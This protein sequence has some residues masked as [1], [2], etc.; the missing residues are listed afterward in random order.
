MS[1]I[2]FSSTSLIY[3][4]QRKTCKRFENVSRNGVAFRQSH[5]AC[6]VT[7]PDNANSSPII[8]F[9]WPLV[10]SV[11]IGFS[12]RIRANKQLIVVM[13]ENCHSVASLLSI[14]TQLCAFAQANSYAQPARMQHVNVVRATWREVAASRHAV[15]FRGRPPLRPFTRAAADFAGDLVAPARFASSD[16]Q[17]FPP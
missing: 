17:R 13:Q 9:V 6:T 15:F 10:T 2:F 1:I 14:F 12:G 16:I 11:G 8:A 7:T 4:S 3:S 5:G